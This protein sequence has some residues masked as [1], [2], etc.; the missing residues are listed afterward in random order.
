MNVACF[1]VATHGRHLQ[2]NVFL[3][4]IVHLKTVSKANGQCFFASEER[5][6][7]KIHTLSHLKAKPS[8]NSLTREVAAISPPW[9][10]LRVSRRSGWRARGDVT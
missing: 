7:A 9:P 6:E 1:P 8:S 3:D 2:K 5:R 10:Q 4:V